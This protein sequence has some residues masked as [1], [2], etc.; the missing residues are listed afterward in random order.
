M[1]RRPDR[2]VHLRISGWTGRFSKSGRCVRGAWRDRTTPVAG[3]TG[4]AASRHA[5]RPCPRRCAPV[6]SSCRPCHKR[7][8]WH[9]ASQAAHLARTAGLP[10]RRRSPK[11]AGRSGPAPRPENRDRRLLR[12]WPPWPQRSGFRCPS[13]WPTAKNALTRPAPGGG[14]RGSAARFPQDPC[15][16]R[17]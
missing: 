13:L 14:L 15:Q 17:T 2:S 5:C 6:P 11:A 12:V 10:R 4:Q 3:E 16:G 7:C 9:Q 8:R 1:T